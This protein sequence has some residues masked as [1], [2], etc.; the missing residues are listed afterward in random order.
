MRLA[1][2]IIRN[3]RIA[4]APSRSAPGARPVGSAAQAGRLVA[5]ARHVFR[6][7]AA[8]LVDALGRQLQHPVGQRGQEV[9]VVR[10]EQHGALVLATAP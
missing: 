9:P 1:A 2:S 4:S 6:V 7:A 8:V 10:D 3:S 5:G